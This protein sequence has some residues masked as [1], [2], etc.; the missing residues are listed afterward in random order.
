MSQH[1]QVQKDRQ[2]ALADYKIDLEAHTQLKELNRKLDILLAVIPLDQLST[3]EAE[4]VKKI[5]AEA[6]AAA[7]EV[8]AE[9]KPAKVAAA[10]APK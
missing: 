5:A 10:P 1:R 6:A 2:G 7:A 8:P 9:I 4:A 3:L